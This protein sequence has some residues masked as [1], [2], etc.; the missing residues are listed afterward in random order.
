MTNLSDAEIDSICDGYK[1]NAAK[2]RYLRNLGLTV[3]TKPNGRPLVNR[4]HFDAMMGCASY[5]SQS[6]ADRLP[7]WGVH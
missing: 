2:V 3:Y 6:K 1:Q 4:A 5:V 7:I